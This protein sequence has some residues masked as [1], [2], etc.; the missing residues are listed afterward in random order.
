MIYYGHSKG[1]Y[2]IVNKPESSPGHFF[3]ALFDVLSCLPWPAHLPQ[4]APA[5]CLRVE[6][7]KGKLV[8]GFKQANS[9]GHANPQ[10]D[11]TKH[12]EKSISNFQ[13][14]EVSI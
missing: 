7:S 5:K 2:D 8:L 4:L 1:V 14:G 6:V 9:S 12:Y 13:A 3:W 10:P 11:Q